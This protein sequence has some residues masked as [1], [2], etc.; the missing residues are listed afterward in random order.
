M[1]S[2]STAKP[3]LQPSTTAAA[4]N[5]RPVGSDFKLKQRKREVVTKH[6]PEAFR[7]SLLELIPEDCDIE[8]YASILEASAEKLDYRK[9]AESFFEFFILGGLVAPGGQLM[10]DGARLNPFSIFAC[11]DSIESIRPRVE[12]LTKLIRRH[13]F[14]QRKLEETLEHLLQYVNKFERDAHKMSTFVGI[15]ISSQMVSMTVLNH[16]MKDHLVKDGASLQF[17][18]GVFQVYLKEQSVDNLSAMLQRNGLDDKLLDFFPPNK[19]QEE[20]LARHFESEGLKT[21]VDFFKKRQASVTKDSMKG[22]LIEQFQE[23]KTQ[24]EIVAFVK[25]QLAANPLTEVEIITLLWD[26]IIESVKWSNRPEQLEGQLTKTITAW[27]KVLEAYCKSPKTEIT[28]IQ[29][30]QAMCYEDARYTKHF[31]TIIVTLYKADVISEAAVLY[32]F[33]KGAIAKGKAMFIE[34]MKPFVDWLKSQDEEEDDE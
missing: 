29:R 23:N 3:Q 7:D 32:W 11:D 20:Y 18:T 15:L 9:Y 26:S 16:L 22:Q 28:L 1:S 8:K 30:I 17:V 5:N 25:Q 19:R 4:A 27:P 12:I 14:M 33:D 10:D 13:K 34:Q 31:R 21:L 6:E 2:A 24:P